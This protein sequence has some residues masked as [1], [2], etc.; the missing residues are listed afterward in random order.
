MQKKKL[1]CIVGETGSG[2]DTLV[3]KLMCE[4]PKQFK[5]V[6]SYTNREIREGETEG[7]E[8]YFV[9]KEEFTK[10][11]KTKRN[12]IVAYTKIAN[13]QGEGYEYMALIEDVKEAN[14]YIIDPNGLKYL[15]DNFGDEIDAV[16]IYI[17]APL[18][19]RKERA[20]TR[21]DYK[22]KFLK[23]VSA[24]Q[25][26][27]DHFYRHRHFDYVIYNLDGMDDTSYETFK[28]IIQYEE[29]ERD[30]GSEYTSVLGDDHTKEELSDAMSLMKTSIEF[31]ISQYT[32]N[33]TLV[34]NAKKNYMLLRN[35]ILSHMR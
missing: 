31:Y 25:A 2:K 24:E 17:Y 12:E 16:V 29:N 21:S 5:A 20:K 7:V 34:R 22:T 30:V 18:K 8:H 1:Y 13:E 32:T 35:L 4:F 14:I 3:N 9:S 19:Q 6:V 10:K 27:F 28:A 26:Q 33:T 23:R 11:Y 15:R